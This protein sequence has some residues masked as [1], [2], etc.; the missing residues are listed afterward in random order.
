MSENPHYAERT[1]EPTT[2][3]TGGG[4]DRDAE[5][6]FDDPQVGGTSDG[7]GGAD[8]H[9]GDGEHA[10]HAQRA[11]TAL[12]GEDAPH[13]AGNDERSARDVGGP[14]AGEDAERIEA[15]EDAELPG[16]AKGGI[17]TKGLDPHE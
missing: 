16:G 10:G 6:R 5:G 7:V 14:R 12:T 11:G 17:R 1:D 13:P 8:S 15:G 3:Q 4:V 2:P 9:E